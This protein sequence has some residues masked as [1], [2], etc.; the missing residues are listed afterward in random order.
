MQP[1]YT[2]LNLE[3]VWPSL[4][5]SRFDTDD[6]LIP[7]L[8]MDIAQR[9]LLQ[10]IVV[11][12]TPDA[13]RIV[14]GRRRLRACMLL[15]WKQIPAHIIEATPQA[16]AEITF[17]ENFHR[18]NLGP[19]E[20]AVIL[21]EMMNQGGYTTEQLAQQLS[22][23]KTW[24]YHRVALL[25]LPE[26]LQDQV[27][28]GAISPS[29]ALELRRVPHIEDRLWYTK[30]AIENGATLVIVRNWV[31]SYLTSTTATPQSEA[32]PDTEQ[33]PTPYTPPPAPRCYA[34][35]ASGPRVALTYEYLCWDC[36]KA[37]KDAVH[38]EKKPQDLEEKGEG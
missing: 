14:A 25:Q 38:P 33:L 29:I 11:V 24:V 23:E 30:L 21:Q 34:C 18:L 2:L 8:A 6:P 1:E 22:V 26:D 31:R 19:L 10:P 13:Y 37:F 9:G 3:D 4:I 12:R 7:R 28:R 15:G 16:Q 36:A 20:E 35:G 32:P 17:A 5:E 27:A